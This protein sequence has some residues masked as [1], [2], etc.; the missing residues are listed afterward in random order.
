MGRRKID[1][2]DPFTGIKKVMRSELSRCGQQTNIH[3]RRDGCSSLL[4]RLSPGCPNPSLHLPL[5]LV[6]ERN[7]VRSLE[8]S[9][10]FSSEVELETAHLALED[11][12]SASILVNGQEVTK[13][14]DGWWVDKATQRLRFSGTSIKNGENTLLIKIT[15]GL[16]SCISFINSWCFC[17]Q[18]SWC[19]ALHL[20]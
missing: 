19:L 14:P 17:T 10:R 20:V 18:K 5:I 3:H 4:L 2:L 7:P 15:F 1:I 6:E 13:T 12:A 11:P 8:L 16:L 9:F